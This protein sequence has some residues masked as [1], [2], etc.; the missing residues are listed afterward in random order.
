MEKFLKMMYRV[1]TNEA[2]HI[3]CSYKIY[4]EDQNDGKNFIKWESVW[5]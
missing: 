1:V 3:I 4:F 2:S 5:F